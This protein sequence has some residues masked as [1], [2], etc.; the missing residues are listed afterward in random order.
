[1]QARIP[2]RAFAD[3]RCPAPGP[4]LTRA[5]E[6]WPTKNAAIQKVV[7][8]VVKPDMT[9]RQAAEALL[10]WL[11]DN[12]PYDGRIVGSRYGT[13]QVLQQKYGHCWDKADLY[14]TL[15]RAAG[16]PARQ[17]FGWM[18]GVSGHVWTQVY[19]DGGWVSVDA[20]TSW[21]G[22]SEDYVPFFLSEEG[23]MPAVYWDIPELEKQ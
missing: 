15:C 5:T 12:V 9:Q 6:A 14:I 1:M 21:L 7:K 17:V 10:G 13:L 8:Q 18:A 16:L 2:V 22:V 20:T 23:D 11:T 4:A 3:Y 19:L